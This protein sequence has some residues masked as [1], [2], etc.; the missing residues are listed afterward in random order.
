MTSQCQPGESRVAASRRALQIH[1]RSFSSSPTAKARGMK[2]TPSS[3]TPSEARLGSC[4]STSSDSTPRGT[5]ATP[6]RGIYEASRSRNRIEAK[7]GRDGWNER[8]TI[9][10]YKGEDINPNGQEPRKC[11]SPTNMYVLLY[12]DTKSQTCI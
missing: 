12:S 5:T 8:I 10:G 11:E 9:G 3:S 1:G 4:S 6:S 2:H 7:E